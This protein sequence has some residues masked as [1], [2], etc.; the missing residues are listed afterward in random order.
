LSTPARRITQP[1]VENATLSVEF[2]VDVGQL[3]ETKKARRRRPRARRM[4][5]KA[6]RLAC[7][8]G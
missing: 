2:G 1:S 3:A 8:P 6:L 7:Q 4:A 5:G